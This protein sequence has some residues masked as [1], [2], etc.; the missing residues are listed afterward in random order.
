MNEILDSLLQDMLSEFGCTV[1]NHINNKLMVDFFYSEEM[2][3]K[4]LSGLECKQGMA[5]YGAGQVLEVNKIPDEKMVVI[6]KDGVEI[7]RYK[8]TSI[9]KSTIVYKERNSDSKV[10]NKSLTFRIRKNKFFELLNFIDT[11]GNS[12]DFSS[13]AEIE[14]YLR[15]KYGAYKYADGS[16]NL[17]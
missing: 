2:Y 8:Y 7:D 13:I 6:K 10:V 14:G 9:V 15:E 3:E 11:G 16:D 1:I 17:E 4:Y 5:M 12:F